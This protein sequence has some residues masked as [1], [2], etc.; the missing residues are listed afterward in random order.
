[1]RWHPIH[2][3]SHYRIPICQSSVYHIPVYQVSIYLILTRQIPIWRTQVHQIS[4][5]FQYNLGNAR[6]RYTRSRWVSHITVGTPAPPTT[7]I[8]LT[9]RP[10]IP[11]TGFNRRLRGELQPGHR[12]SLSPVRARFLLFRRLTPPLH[13]RYLS[14]DYEF[15]I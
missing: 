12:G 6:S 15:T 9:T 2:S 4:I 13:R 5:G 14:L 10:R 11:G 3:I 8:S 7:C 1:M